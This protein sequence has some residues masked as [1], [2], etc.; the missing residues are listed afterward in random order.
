[1]YVDHCQCVCDELHDG[2]TCQHTR[3]HLLLGC[4]DQCADGNT[5]CLS[6]C[7]TAPDCGYCFSTRT[8]MRKDDVYSRLQCE[9]FEVRNC[10]RNDYTTFSEGDAVTYVYDYYVVIVSSHVDAGDYVYFALYASQ[11]FSL[12]VYDI[13]GSNRGDPDII[14]SSYM[15]HPSLSKYEHEYHS[16]SR[17][18]DTLI[19]DSMPKMT[20]SIS[21]YIYYDNGTVIVDYERHTAGQ[22]DVSFEPGTF[23]IAVYGATASDFALEHAYLVDPSTR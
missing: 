18:N 6:D 20:S 21:R 5:Y 4:R 11:P 23:Y 13:K 3:C 15:F 10:F 1:M 16:S 9:R 12:H 17:G 14:A 2:D 8:C 22:Q 7:L 19:I